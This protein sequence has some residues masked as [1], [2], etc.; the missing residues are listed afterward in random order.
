MPPRNPDRPFPIRP[1]RNVCLRVAM[2]GF[3]MVFSQVMWHQ[4]PTTS[5]CLGGDA[6]LTL[7]PK[8][9]NS[10]RTEQ[11]QF[12]RCWDD[13]TGCATRTVGP[14]WSPAVLSLK[15]DA[16]DDRPLVEQIVVGIR[17]EIE[18][19]HLRPGTRIPSIRSFAERHRISRFTV[20]EAYD[21]LVAMGYLHSR[22]GAGFYAQSP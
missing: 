20:V 10:Q 1:P 2:C 17:R 8:M 21:R 15:I 4:R 18:E 6:A 14:N 12:P 5:A 11:G 3:V 7:R 16:D 13:C 19:R 22:R 9:Q